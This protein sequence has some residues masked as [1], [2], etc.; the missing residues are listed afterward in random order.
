[1]NNKLIIS[2]KTSTLFR[3]FL[4]IPCA[5]LLLTTCKKEDTE[6]EKKESLIRNMSN[7]ISSDSLE[8][9]V[10][11]LQNMGTRFTLAGNRRSVAARIMNKFKSFGYSEARLDSFFIVKTYRNVQYSLWQYNVI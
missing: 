11:W 10:L 9:D 4:I 7:D 1:M 6:E 5:L 3:M 8:A 2:I